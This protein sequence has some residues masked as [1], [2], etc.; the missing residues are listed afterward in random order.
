MWNTYLPLTIDGGKIKVDQRGWN[1]IIS[2]DFGLEVKYDWNMMLYIT[3]PSS[4][5]QTV[6]GLCGNYNGD[7]RDEFIDPKGQVLSS[8]IAFAKTWKFPDNDLFCNDDCNGQCPSCS[9]SL[10]EEY[11]K[12]TNCGVMAKTDG[13]FAICHDTVDPQMY[14]DNCVYDVCINNGMRR[15]LCNNIQSYVDAC[16][17]AGIKIPGKWRT[18]SNCRK[19]VYAYTF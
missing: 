11:K 15:F 13:P 18:L 14:V 16:M 5:F 4:Y 7:R 2:T 17:S 8:V 6:G 3:A 1:V 9:L 19:C 10:Q 12:D